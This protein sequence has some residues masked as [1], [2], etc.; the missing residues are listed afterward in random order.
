MSRLSGDVEGQL[1]PQKHDF[2]QC[3]RDKYRTG[4]IEIT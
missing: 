4:Q 2:P 3:D 1:P